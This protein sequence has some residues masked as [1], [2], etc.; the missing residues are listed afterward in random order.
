MSDD[1]L[2][3][4]VLWLRDYKNL[5]NRHI[6]ELEAEGSGTDALTLGERH[7]REMQELNARMPVSGLKLYAL[8]ETVAGVA[9]IDIE[10]QKAVFVP[11][12]N[13]MALASARKKYGNDFV[14]WI[15]SN[16]PMIDRT[17]MQ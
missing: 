4:Y 14:D 3:N 7:R 17:M 11:G 2:R 8:R 10:R 9:T 1:D 15:V 6:G 5:L 12:R 13:E 16:E